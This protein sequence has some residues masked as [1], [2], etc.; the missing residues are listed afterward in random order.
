MLNRNM[1][2]LLR[3]RGWPTS[4]DNWFLRY[5]N[6]KI[7]PGFAKKGTDL[8]TFSRL[9][10]LDMKNLSRNVTNLLR[11]R[12]WATSYGNWF[13]RYENPKIQPVFAKKRLAKPLLVGLRP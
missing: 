4:Y 12:G 8:A 6:P 10:A 7:Q 1:T 3:L 9:T 5:E 2:N 13:L 11:L